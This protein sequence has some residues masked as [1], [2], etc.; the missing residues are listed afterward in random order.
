MG[1]YI[2]STGGWYRPD[3]QT[4]CWP[5]EWNSQQPYPVYP[6]PFTLPP[7]IVYYQAPP[8]KEQR[9]NWLDI[10]QKVFALPPATRDKVFQLVSLIAELTQDPDIKALVD[11]LKPKAQS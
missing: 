6:Q 8:I 4:G 5:P 2:D 11:S 7:T 9:M 10:V 1:G 3:T